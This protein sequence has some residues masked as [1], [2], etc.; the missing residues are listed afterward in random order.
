[1]NGRR[2]KKGHFHRNCS[3][4]YTEYDERSVAFVH[5]SPDDLRV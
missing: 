2:R 4:N 5:H 3:W 1:M